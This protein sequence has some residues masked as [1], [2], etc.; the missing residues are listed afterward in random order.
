MAFL[1]MG[2]SVVSAYYYTVVIRVMLMEEAVDTSP[3]KIS[4]SLKLVMIIS[5]VM[6]IIMGVYPGPITDWTNSVASSF[7]FIK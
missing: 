1:A 6:I 3:I 4:S 5:I 2:M 7:T